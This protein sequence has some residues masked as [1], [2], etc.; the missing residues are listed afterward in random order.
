MEPELPPVFSGNLNDLNGKTRI[1]GIKGVPQTSAT[2]S[3]Q[4]SPIGA[5]WVAEITGLTTGTSYWFDIA[6]SGRFLYVQ[7]V[8]IYLEEKY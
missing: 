7:D 8:Q 2:P 6:M 4:L 3:L 5:S 1:G